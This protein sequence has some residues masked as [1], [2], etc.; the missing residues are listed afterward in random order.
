MLKRAQTTIEYL[1][2]LTAFFSVL[3]LFVPLIE[4]IYSKSIELI[5]VKNAENFLETLDFK[6]QELFLM[7]K[8]STIK[9]NFS[10]SFEWFLFYE[11]QQL[12]LQIIFEEK[13]RVLTKKVL[14][15]IKV[16]SIPLT[17]SKTVLLVKEDDLVLIKNF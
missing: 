7:E 3:L 12:V 2:V 8:S 5:E 17:L 1:I 13:N 11:N 16:D 4:K 15:P 14:Y 9:I 10:H 6:V